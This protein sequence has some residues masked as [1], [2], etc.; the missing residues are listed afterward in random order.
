MSGFLWVFGLC[1]ILLGITTA[2]AGGV[3]LGEHDDKGAL[4]LGLA[5]SLVFIVVGALMWRFA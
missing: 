1:L 5:A 2:G 3:Q 4:R